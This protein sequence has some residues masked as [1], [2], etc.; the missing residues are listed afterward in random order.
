MKA[1][2]DRNRALHA[3]RMRGTN[4]RKWC[5]AEG[6]GYR[7]ASN[8]LR[9]LSRAQFGAGKQIADKLNALIQEAV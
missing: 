8:V 1:V 3:L 2:V 7:N 9:G 4:L 6:F 5:E